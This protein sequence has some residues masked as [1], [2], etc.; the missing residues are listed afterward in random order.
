MRGHRA[1]ANL[2]YGN[3]TTPRGIG[4]QQELKEFREEIKDGEYTSAL[5]FINDNLD[6]A[7]DR[8][9]REL[10]P[11]VVRAKLRE[12]QIEAEREHRK[13]QVARA[14]SF[15][16][17]SERK[18][19]A[20]NEI[21]TLSGR[22]SKD[23]LDGKVGWDGTFTLGQLFDYQTPI[24][25]SGPIQRESALQLLKLLEE[26]DPEALNVAL[27]AFKKYGTQNGYAA[28]SWQL[29]PLQLPLEYLH[30]SLERNALL[31]YR[32]PPP[33]IED[34]DENRYLPSA[35]Y[36][37]QL[38]G[39]L[40]LSNQHLKKWVDPDYQEMLVKSTGKTH[41]RY[42]GTKLNEAVC[43][44]SSERGDVERGVEAREVVTAPESDIC[45][46][47]QKKVAGKPFLSK[48]VRD[49]LEKES[50]HLLRISSS[51]ESWETLQEKTNQLIRESCHGELVF[52]HLSGKRE[53]HDTQAHLAKLLDDESLKGDLLS[54][55]EWRELLS[56]YDTCDPNHGRIKEWLIKRK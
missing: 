38:T 50:R 2:L 15:F 46:D 16:D 39:F 47:C 41:F 56:L 49:D 42:K 27:D 21:G 37:K 4:W 8:K 18:R 1:Q 45:P 52:R 33:E 26:R 25:E 28:K 11:L 7:I 5:R 44:F 17:I 13:R 24:N 29:S 20:A 23:I 19:L 9:L 36:L 55:G 48:G 3:T 10:V 31:D 40:G 14:K 53:S 54:R 6:Q 35:D 30:R 51:D 12:A 22:L 43:G 32:E 34:D